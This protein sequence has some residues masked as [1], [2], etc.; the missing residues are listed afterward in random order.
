MVGKQS[1]LF[2]IRTV[3]V[4]HIA[5]THSTTVLLHFDTFCKRKREKDE[6]EE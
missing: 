6:Q 3:T 4:E 1:L 2:S 5:R